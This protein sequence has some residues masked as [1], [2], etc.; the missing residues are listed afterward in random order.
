MAESMYDDNYLPVWPWVMLIMF[1]MVF[2]IWLVCCTDTAE[3]TISRDNLQSVMVDAH[4]SCG[5]PLVVQKVVVESHDN[6]RWDVI[7]EADAAMY[8]AVVCQ[9][10]K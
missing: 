3:Y 7:S 6:A 1:A 4:T 5:D 9:P 10:A 2:G 8:V